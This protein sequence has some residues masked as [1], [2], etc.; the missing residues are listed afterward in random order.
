[1]SAR[2]IFINSVS[3]WLICF[4]PENAFEKLCSNKISLFILAFFKELF[5]AK[6]VL[7]A[8]EIGFVVYN[9][10]LLLSILLGLVGAMGC[11]FILNL[12]SS[13]SSA[14]EKQIEKLTPSD[15]TKMAF[16]FSSLHVFA[17]SGCEIAP[18][19]N[20]IITCQALLMFALAFLSKIGKPVS[21]FDRLDSLMMRI[22]TFGADN[23]EKQE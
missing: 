22:L 4:T 19:K 8:A 20:M 15:F 21:V 18:G 9:G 17:L 11:E 6:K 5:R 16:F 14:Q 23:K 2:T 10:N 12:G 3:W 13:L 7:Y 1:M